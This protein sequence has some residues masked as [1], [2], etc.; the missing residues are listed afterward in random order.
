MNKWIVTG[1]LASNPELRKTQ[2]G[3]SVTTFTLAVDDGF[4]DK[5]T[6]DFINCVI[7]N[8]PAETF[9]TYLSKGSK[10]AIEA[11]IKSRSYEKDGHKRYV[12]E[13]VVDN[14]EFLD[15]KKKEP[16]ADATEASAE[17]A[18]EYEVE[19]FRELTDEDLPF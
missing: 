18:G 8:K 9:A 19:T 6:T 12:V 14:Y 3:K 4:G 7:W 2:T 1:R 13:A 11:R 15:S 17:P 10:V 16:A 5:K